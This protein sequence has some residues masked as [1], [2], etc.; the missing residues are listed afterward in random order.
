MIIRRAAI[1]AAGAVAA[2]ALVLGQAAEKPFPIYDALGG[3]KTGRPDLVKRDGLKV[4]HVVYASSIF[5]P[6]PKGKTAATGWPQTLRP[7]D[8]QRL[9]AIAAALERQDRGSLLCLDIE[10][11]PITGDDAEA[12]RSV[13]NYLHVVRVVRQAAPSLRVGFYGVFPWPDYHLSDAPD[14][15]ARVRGFDAVNARTLAIGQAVDVVMPSLYAYA[16]SY[17]QW[18]RFA[19]ESLRAARLAGKPVYPYIWPEYHDGNRAHAG[20]FLPGDY[21]RQI[22]EDVYAQAEGAVLWSGS[23]SVGRGGDPWNEQW[24]WWQIFKAFAK[25]HGI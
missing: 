13:D 2:I 9:A 24:E 12:R 17:P 8:E 21:W 25:Q 11:W 10:H 22:L 7:D 18:Q 15:A 20:T 16:D 5:G 3:Y 19:N 6:L 14:F 4:I 23:A 1:T